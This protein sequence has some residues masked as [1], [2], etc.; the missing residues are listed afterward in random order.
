[1]SRFF[2]KFIVI[3][4]IFGLLSVSAV[5]AGAASDQLRGTQFLYVLNGNTLAGTNDQGTAFH[6]YFLAGGTATYEDAEGFRDVGE[7]TVREDTLLCVRWRHM[8]NG[9]ERC[10]TASLS[11][12]TLIFKGG[13]SSSPIRVIGTIAP[14]H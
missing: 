1:M 2:N 8:E 7:W 14:G 3:Y 10:G 13:L 11:G 9:A 5:T 4:L 12:K 6:A